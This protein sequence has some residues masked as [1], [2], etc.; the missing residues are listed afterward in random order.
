MSKNKK[1]KFTESIWT[2]LI[3]SIIIGIPLG[4][5]TMGLY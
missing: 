1:Y 4:F 5:C 3:L 2:E